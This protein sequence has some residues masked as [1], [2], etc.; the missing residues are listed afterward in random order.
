MSAHLQLARS[1]H[2]ICDMNHVFL[3]LGNHQQ[4]GQLFKRCRC[5]DL[6]VA[7]HYF[8]QNMCLVW[9]LFGVRHDIV[10]CGGK[11]LDLLLTSRR[12]TLSF[13]SL[14][15]SARSATCKPATPRFGFDLTSSETLLIVSIHCFF[16]CVCVCFHSFYFRDHF[17]Y[18]PRHNICTTITVPR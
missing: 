12:P 8:L 17:L 4:V 14:C 2:R 3:P 6:T 16:F 7:G 15:G 5:S 1:V 10:G 9:L 13:P 18:F 11:I